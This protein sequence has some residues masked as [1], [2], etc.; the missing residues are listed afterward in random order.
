[1]CRTVCRRAERRIV[2]LARL[3]PQPQTLSAYINRLKLREAERLLATGDTSVTEIAEAVGFST[4]SYF[5]SL[6][7]SHHGVTP[8]KYRS[9]LTGE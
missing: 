4:V 2:A 8:H 7:R 1:M 5:I 9:Q 3:S 6:F